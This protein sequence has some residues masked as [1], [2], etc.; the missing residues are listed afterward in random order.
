MCNFEDL[1]SDIL[2]DIITRLPI[3]SILDSKLV[4]KPLRNLVSHHPKFS[5][6]HLDR[7]NQLADSGE[8]SFILLIDN[9]D[10]YYFEYIEK[11][12]EKKPPV[13]SIK[14]INVTLPLEFSYYKVLG[15]FNGLVCLYGWKD[16]DNDCTAC[17]CNP[18][19]REYVEL[20]KINSIERDCDDMCIHLSAGFGYLPLT[21]EYK[22]VELYKLRGEFDFIE[23]AVY[24]LGG[25]NG[26]R[27]VGRIHFQSSEKYSQY[28]VFA[29]GALHWV[30][31]IVGT[32][33]V[34]D[35]TEE[36]FSG[37][38]SPPPMPAN[39]IWDYSVGVLG[40]VLYCTVEYND[41]I[42]R[43]CSYSELW[44]L[45][46]KNDI[47]GIIEQVEQEPLGWTKE[48]LCF[49]RKMQLAFT[50]SGGP[51]CFDD[52]SFD[53][54]DSIAST[55]K[56]L[57]VGLSAGNQI[58]PHKNTLVSLKELGEDTKIMENRKPDS[59]IRI[60]LGTLINRLMPKITKFGIV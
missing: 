3:E 31:E 53:I 49:P 39:S 2:L 40:R 7:L 57:I 23:V 44:R 30:D 4:C 21:N 41:L 20:P 38:V 37:Y 34:F 47:H 9:Q 56:E 12:D 60:F 54:Y 25:G 43:G 51:L 15:S 26:W 14:R 5:Q 18:M 19:T 27:N 1:Q 46:A 58:F 17:I 33:L 16:T 6:L 24:T 59:K 55:L 22:V 32:V 50:K 29:N 13:H 11:H 36:T 28:G 10:L 42:I 52:R 8:L 45:T 48:V 35:L